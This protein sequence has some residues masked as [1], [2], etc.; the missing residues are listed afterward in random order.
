MVWT[1][2]ENHGAGLLAE[3]GGLEPG[4]EVHRPHRAA[5]GHGADLVVGHR[6]NAPVGELGDGE[7]ALG[8]RA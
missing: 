2:G 3:Q 6:M 5:H 7:H 1:R 8:G 4:D